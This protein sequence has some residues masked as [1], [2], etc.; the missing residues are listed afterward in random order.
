MTCEYNDTTQATDAQIAFIQAEDKRQY[1]RLVE[2]FKQCQI[3]R[4]KLR[5][6]CK[7]LR[8]SLKECVATVVYTRELRERAA[9]VLEDTRLD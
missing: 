4:D 1:S 8:E 2:E 7:A 5:N 9:Q 3:E 6:A